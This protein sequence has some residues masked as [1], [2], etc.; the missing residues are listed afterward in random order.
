[1]AYQG[2]ICRD[3][4]LLSPLDNRWSCDYLQASFLRGVPTRTSPSETQF[5]F[6]MHPDTSLLEL[7]H[8]Q[9]FFGPEL[10]SDLQLRGSDREPAY[11]L[12]NVQNQNA[13][14]ARYLLSLNRNLDIRVH[15]SQ[16]LKEELL[17]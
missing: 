2:L 3:Y 14:L 17:H 4:S 10:S 16:L 9:I 1:M 13:G 15:A 6:E 8:S 7:W 5:S 11:E 12:Q